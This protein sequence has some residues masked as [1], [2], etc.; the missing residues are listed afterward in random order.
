MPLFES[1]GVPASTLKPP[2]MEAPLS[3]DPLY[4]PYFAESSVCHLPPTQ[5]SL[6]AGTSCARASRG[7]TQRLASNTV[8]KE[9]FIIIAISLTSVVYL[10]VRST[11]RPGCLNHG[12]WSGSS[13][14]RAP[15]SGG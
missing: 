7:N 2:T 1:Q 14:S 11:D 5:T 4:L 9:R 6:L 10:S 15:A 13:R 8:L 3:G 12:Y